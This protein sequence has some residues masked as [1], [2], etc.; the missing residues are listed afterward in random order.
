MIVSH[1]AMLWLVTLVIVTKVHPQLVMFIVQYSSVCLQNFC[2]ICIS[3][4]CSSDKLFSNVSNVMIS[5]VHKSTN[6]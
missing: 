6:H 2:G 3:I 5:I 4:V 1:R